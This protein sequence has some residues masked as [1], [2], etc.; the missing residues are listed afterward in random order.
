M[1]FLSP[2]LLFEVKFNSE[3]FEL[4]SQQPESFAKNLISTVR[5]DIIDKKLP[6]TDKLRW[7]ILPRYLAKYDENDWRVREPHIS[8]EALYWL[9]AER[10]L[11]DI[12]KILKEREFYA[13][14]SFGLGLIMSGIILKQ[15]PA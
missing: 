4:F 12:G 5:V 13:D 9:K 11:V 7:L 14:F 6:E 2:P 1:F 8:P 3:L 10:I 15:A